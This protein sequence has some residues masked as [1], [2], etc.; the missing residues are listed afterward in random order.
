MSLHASAISLEVHLASLSLLRIFKSPMTLRRVMQLKEE[1]IEGQY[2]APA[3]KPNSMT[4][5]QAY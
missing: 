3:K 4:K 1:G 2:V 5:E